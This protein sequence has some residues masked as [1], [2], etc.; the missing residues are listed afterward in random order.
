MKT[1]VEFRARRFPPSDGALATHLR[2][3][4]RA[5]GVEVGEI[6]EEDWGWVLPVSNEAFPLWIGCGPRDDVP[7]GFLCFLEPSRPRIRRWLRTIDTSGP[8]ARLAETLDRV[9]AEDPGTEDV[10]WWSEE[11]AR[12]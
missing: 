8:V 6:V 2:D 9:L 10:R 5:A 3:R 4:L 7:G 12:V 1:R 11:E